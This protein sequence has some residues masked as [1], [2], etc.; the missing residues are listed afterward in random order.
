MTKWSSLINCSTAS[1][2]FFVNQ[3]EVR[4]LFAI[5]KWRIVHVKYNFEHVV[6]HLGN[7]LDHVFVWSSKVWVCVYF[8]EPY[9]EIFIQQE[10]ESEQFETVLSFVG[11][12]FV[13][14]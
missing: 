13:A 6:N 7:Q 4:L 11:I 1:V 3:L 8:N 10:V 14:H 2:C 5:V 12:H 9:A